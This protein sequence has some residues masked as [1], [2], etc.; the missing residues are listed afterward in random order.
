MQNF[1]TKVNCY[2]IATSQSKNILSCSS[3]DAVLRGALSCWGFRADGS[4][5][6]SDRHSEGLVSLF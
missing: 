6:V 2:L 1:P 3:F 5:S 4:R